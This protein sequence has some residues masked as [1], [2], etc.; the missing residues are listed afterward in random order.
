M[1]RVN[2]IVLLS[3]AAVL[4]LVSGGWL[5]WSRVYQNPDRIFWDMMSTNLSTTGVTRVMKQQG[6]GLSVSQY[7][8]VSFT[9]TPTV[10]ALTVFKQSG[11]TLATEEISDKNHDYVRYRQIHVPTKA[12]KE[13]DASAILG[14]WARLGDGQTVGSQLT[15]GLYNQSL[16]D[17]LPMGN[18]APQERSELL[19]TMRKE[20]TF[21]Y[22]DAS[23]KKV[24]LN[25]RT[26]YLYSVN[27]QP[28]SYVQ[29][30]QRFEK[31]VGG[32][33]YTSLKPNDFNGAKPIAIVLSVDARSHVLSQMYQTSSQRTLSYE[34]FGVANTDPMPK[35]TIT[36][37]ELTKRL[38]T[39]QTQ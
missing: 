11:N 24:K 26:T 4:L 14:K 3:C 32:T 21:S 20:K 16:L 6:N 34:G 35:A 8:Q 7:T 17:V 12:G 19:A 15:G 9:S 27:I 13:L 22:S 5:W 31:L 23:V 1:T 18:I 33:L 10:R 2:R 30:M 36:A 39:L 38:S 37:A 25:G 28:K 29:L